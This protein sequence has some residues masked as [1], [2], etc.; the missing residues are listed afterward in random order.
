MQDKEVYENLLNLSKNLT[1]LLLHAST[2]ASTDEVFDAF[3]DA[4]E[5]AVEMQHQIYKCMED[6]GFYQVTQVN[7]TEITNVQN[8]FEECYC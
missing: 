5:S 1:T 3:S 6:C 4:L 2:E 7:Q 8:K